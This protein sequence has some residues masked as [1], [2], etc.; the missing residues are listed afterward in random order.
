MS[1]KLVV[2]RKNLGS[3]RN[4]VVSTTDLADGVYLIQLV[5]SENINID[6]KMIIQNK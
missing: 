4:L 1:G 3:E 5:T 6:Y 2:T